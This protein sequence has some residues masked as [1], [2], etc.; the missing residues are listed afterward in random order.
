MPKT[1]AFDRLAYRSAYSRRVMLRMLIRIGAARGFAEDAAGGLDGDFRFPES[2][3]EAEV[4]GQVAAAQVWL[5]TF[6]L[7]HG[8][9]EDEA[10]WKERVR[11]AAA[12]VLADKA[13]IGDWP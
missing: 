8:F 3:Y 1:I 6:E 12:E 9:A 13:I 2:G 5:D 10:A 11:R 4:P 7:E